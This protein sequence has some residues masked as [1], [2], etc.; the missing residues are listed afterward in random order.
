M[1]HIYT[2]WN[3]LD[4]LFF[5][6]EQL[7]S[8]AMEYKTK[9]DVECMIEAETQFLKIENESLK[10][11]QYPKQVFKSNKNY[12]CPNH[13]CKKEISS[14]LVEK[15][16]IK[17]C[18]ECGQRIYYNPPLYFEMSETKNLEEFKNE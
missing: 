7:I 10:S 9:P 3:I 11:L 17:F 16:R 12:I 18:P 6:I 2:K 13:H 14:V 15:Y 4:N 1:K 8:I 5:S